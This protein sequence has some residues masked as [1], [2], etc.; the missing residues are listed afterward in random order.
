MSFIPKTKLSPFYPYLFKF[1]CCSLNVDLNRNASKTKR[2]MI[3]MTTVLYSELFYTS[4]WVW[5]FLKSS[6]TWPH[7]AQKSSSWFLLILNKM[8]TDDS[9]AVN[10]NFKVWIGFWKPCDTRTT[11]RVLFPLLLNIMATTQIT[12]LAWPLYEEAVSVLYCLSCRRLLSP[13]FP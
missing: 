12:V 4:A 5:S 9:N 2:E 10:T 13:V 8:W 6:F 7:A 3:V 11:W 1:I